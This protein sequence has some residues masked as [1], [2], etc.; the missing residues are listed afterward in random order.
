M[1]AYGPDHLVTAD[2]VR[3]LL[4]V[5]QGDKASKGFMTTTSD[6]APKL[7]DDILLKP[8]MPAQLELING[9]ML[10]ARLEE[11]AKKKA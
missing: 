6:F 3:A 7:R 1:R 4:G 9:K 5:L 8:Y 2:D 10:L 11:L